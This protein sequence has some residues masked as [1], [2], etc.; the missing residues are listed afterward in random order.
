MP[1]V[2]DKIAADLSETFTTFP[3]LGEGFMTTHWSVVDDFTLQQV[4]PDR[5]QAALAR[6][7]RD[8]WPPLYRFVRLRGYSRDDAKDL[9]QGFFAYLL[10]KQAFAKPDR[11]KGRFRTFLLVLLKRY[12]GASRAHQ[13]RQ[14]RGGAEAIVF[15]DH[16]QLDLLEQG[17]EDALSTG[18]PLDE[19]RLFEWNWA[20]ALVHRALE[21]LSA[22]YS[23]SRKA[24]VFAELRPFLT[25][26]VG[27]P[28]KEA[29]AAHLDVSMETLRSHLFRLRARYRELLRAEVRRTVL[30]AQGVDDELRYLCRVLIASA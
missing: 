7:C 6:L 4:A 22:E 11:T 8:Y 25:G 17:V 28:T 23:S 13:R 2:Q 12:L 21:S 29:A 15:L 19:E 1:P 3:T 10:E 14:K 5:A 16:G 20:A 27:L 18:A 26:G 24:R 30:R 9:T